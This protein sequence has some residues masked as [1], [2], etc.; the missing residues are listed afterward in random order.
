MANIL[1]L[2]KISSGK[3][4]I[5]NTHEELNLDKEL[6]LEIFASLLPWT[7]SRVELSESRSALGK[8]SDLKFADLLKESS[9]ISSEDKK[10]MNLLLDNTFNVESNRSEEFTTIAEN[11]RFRSFLKFYL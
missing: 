5:Q 10:V 11:I 3:Q 4:L 9:I 6:V 1:D 2:F 8:F 7:I